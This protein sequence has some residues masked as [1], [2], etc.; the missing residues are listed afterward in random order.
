[1]STCQGAVTGNEVAG[2][3]APV[4]SPGNRLVLFPPWPREGGRVDHD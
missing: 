2:V 3:T 1:M 4:A